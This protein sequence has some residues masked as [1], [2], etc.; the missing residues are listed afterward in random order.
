MEAVRP[1]SRGSGTMHTSAGCFAFCAA[2][3]GSALLPRPPLTLLL[4]CCSQPPQVLAADKTRP[5]P[6]AFIIEHWGGAVLTPQSKPKHGDLLAGVRAKHSLMMMGLM[7][8]EELAAPTTAYLNAVS[9][10]VRP[11][12]ARAVALGAAR[13]ARRCSPFARTRVVSVGVH[14]PAANH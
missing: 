11:R 9:R 1:L 6:T 12:A 2:A 10:A 7:P 8:V 5:P 3:G 13:A 14:C 4:T